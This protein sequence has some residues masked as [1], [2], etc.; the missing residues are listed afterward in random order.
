MPQ[1]DVHLRLRRSQI[2][3]RALSRWPLEDPVALI[4]GDRRG[5]AFALAEAWFDL[6]PDDL[7]GMVTSGDHQR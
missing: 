4:S 2:A 5:I 1:P 7:V 3:R 6:A